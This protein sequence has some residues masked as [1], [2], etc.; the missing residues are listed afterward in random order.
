MFNQ[1]VLDALKKARRSGSWLVLV[2]HLG[3][4]GKVK[5]F[6]KTQ[7]F[8]TSALPIA[9]AT[10][11]KDLNQEHARFTRRRECDK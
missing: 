3:D 4:D 5:L 9:R 7:N 6:R 11:A 1:Q 8:P 2:A 10:I